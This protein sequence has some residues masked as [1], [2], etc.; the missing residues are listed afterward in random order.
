MR[1]LDYTDIKILGEMK[2]PRDFLVRLNVP[3]S[4]TLFDLFGEDLEKLAEIA[5]FYGTIALEAYV[6]ASENG[7][8]IL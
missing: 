1:A 6:K 8:H 2:V 5:E 3:S 4:T 7:E